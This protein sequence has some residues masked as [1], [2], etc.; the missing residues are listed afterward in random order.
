MKSTYMYG[1]LIY[2]T[3]FYF[4]RFGEAAAQSWI[5]CFLLVALTVIVMKLM[6]RKTVYEL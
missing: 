6:N 3:G 2:D 1:M 5:L 4:F